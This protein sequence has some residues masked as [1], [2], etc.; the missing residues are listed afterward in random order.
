MRRAAADAPRL[1]PHLS[2]ASLPSLPHNFRHVRAPLHAVRNSL[3]VHHACRAPCLQGC[4]KDDA[5]V[6][7]DEEEANLEVTYQSDGQV[8][9]HTLFADDY[10]TTVRAPSGSWVMLVEQ[11]GK[12][13]SSKIDNEVDI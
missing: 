3:A 12:V 13:G 7:S 1:P 5:S 6:N 8:I 11:K 2:C 4:R 10:A 9:S